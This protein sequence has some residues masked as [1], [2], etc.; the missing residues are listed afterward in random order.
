MLSFILSKMNMLIFA[1][2]MFAI[3]LLM[4]SFTS[5]IELKNITNSNLNLNVQVI[6]EQ[7]NMDSLCSWKSIAIPDTLR[8]GLNNSNQLFY[9][10]KFSTSVLGNFT[11]LSLSINERGKENIIDAK[12]IIT[13]AKVI[14]IDPGFI[15]TDDPIAPYY[16]SG[17][18][19]SI[20]L[21]PRLGL[22]GEQ[23]VAPNSFVALKRVV[24]GEE[25]LYIIPC[26]TA[27]N[28]IPNN[29]VANILRVG[30]YELQRES[31]PSTPND[32][33][34]IHECFNVARQEDDFSNFTWS[35]CKN[36]YAS[37]LS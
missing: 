12:R 5:S 16:K 13:S 8:F 35:D 2:A 9:E 34:P 17:S 28:E 15:I 11:A 7:L 29:C 19:K 27:K 23:V 3:A 6:E 22:R 37:N 36:F 20:S 32:D 10:L 30:C 1:T 18:D 4:L 26:S 21:F 33:A 25:K 24:G 31:L 14:L